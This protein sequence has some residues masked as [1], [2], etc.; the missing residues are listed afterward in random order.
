MN[1]ILAVANLNLWTMIVCRVGIFSLIELINSDWRFSDDIR[2][3]LP[4]LISKGL[5]ICVIE[6]VF[7]FTL[8]NNLMNL[9][10][11]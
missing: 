9:V 10:G 2:I 11:L 1:G 7:L 8:V 6:D 5:I 4:R 3:I